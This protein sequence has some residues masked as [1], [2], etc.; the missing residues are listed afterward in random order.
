MGFRFRIFCFFFV[1]CFSL[2]VQAEP[3]AISE[4]LKL[5]LRGVKQK[6]ILVNVWSVECEICGHEVQELNAIHQSSKAADLVYLAGMAINSK[7]R[8]VKAFVKKFNPQYP[9]IDSDDELIKSVKAVPT[10]FLID[11]NGRVL[12]IWTGLVTAK[13]ILSTID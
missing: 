1:V 2:G 3:S 10:T 4:S 9:Q 5:Q 11:R 13:E 12:K 6:F 7:E 8:N